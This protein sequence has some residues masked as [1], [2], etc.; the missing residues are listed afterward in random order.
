MRKYLTIFA[1]IFAL[2]IYV[3]VM[4]Q[5]IAN[6][7]AQLGTQPPNAP[8]SPSAHDSY[9]EGNAKAPQLRSSGWYGFF[10]WPNGVTAWAIILTLLAIA[11]QTKQTAKA[12]V[13]T[14][15]SVESGKDA[16]KRQLRAYLVVTIGGAV[17]QEREKGI[18][19]A[20]HPMLTNTGQTPAHNVKVLAK[21]EIFPVPLPKDT[22]LSEIGD[23]L[24]ETI[25]GV[26]QPANMNGIVSVF[27]HDDEIE[28][29]KA[30]SKGKSLYTW[31]LVTYKD[32]FGDEHYTRFCQQIYWLPDGKVYGYYTPGRNEAT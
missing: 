4:D 3:S 30:A 23:D 20:A 15:A 18:R 19:F 28:N 8:A 17:Y 25:L 22:S 31:G 24:G 29:I 13:A 32:V 12:A 6:Q 11:E 16:A 2:S 5:H 10:A 9:T 26:N 7:A 27:C 14:E 21:A 1:V